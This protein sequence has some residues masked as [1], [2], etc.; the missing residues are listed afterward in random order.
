MSSAESSAAQQAENLDAWLSRYIKRLDLK[1]GASDFIKRC[2]E[3]E[4]STPRW[5]EEAQSQIESAI[6]AEL[7]N[8]RGTGLVNDR[9]VRTA[10]KEVWQTHE[11]SVT[12]GSKTHCTSFREVFAAS[13]WTHWIAEALFEAIFFDIGAEVLERL[14]G[15]P[16]PKE[17]L[18]LERRTALQGWRDFTTIPGYPYRPLNAEEE[19]IRL[20]V[21]LPSLDD[22]ATIQC[23]LISSKKEM[24]STYVALSY[25]W[26]Q[27]DSENSSRIELE[28]QTFEVTPNLY[29]A[30]RRLR[31]Q[32]T[33]IYLWVDALCINQANT[34]ERNDQVSRMN[35]IYQNATLVVCFLGEEEKESDIA[36]EFLLNLEEAEH[37]A[38][39]LRENWSENSKPQVY[40]LQA[41]LSRKYWKRVWIMQEI[42]LAQHVYICCGKYIISWESLAAFL[43]P[44]SKG[45]FSGTAAELYSVVKSTAKAWVI[46]LISLWYKKHNGIPI[47]R[48][49]VL[50]MSR[51]RKPTV[52]PDYVYGVTGLFDTWTLK[53]DYET[54]VPIFYLMVA[55]A[56]ITDE[57]NLDALSMCKGFDP[58]RQISDETVR[59]TI[60]TGAKGLV[61]NKIVSKFDARGAFFELAFLGYRCTEVDLSKDPQLKEAVQ[62]LWVRAG[63]E[64]LPSWVPRLDDN[65]I[66]P[67]QYILLN[68]KR[69]TN[70]QASGGIPSDSHLAASG[71]ELV[72]KGLILDQISCV[73]TSISKPKKFPTDF[74]DTMANR[75]RLSKAFFGPIRKDWEL[76]NAKVN[77]SHRWKVWDKRQRD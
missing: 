73:S 13:Q 36:M 7:Q 59:N 22:S 48:L 14:L 10:L 29:S 39:W 34:E 5:P 19:E 63:L 76:W 72:V 3:W 57:E 42:V 43:V 12:T 65:G 16:L 45:E 30:L 26:G 27:K 58:D 4:H 51:Q 28:G 11:E 70:D 62:S 67:F 2:H 69:N 6:L 74:E 35:T 37:K 18:E 68:R 9:S 56:A 31:S 77:K 15:R 64:T 53:I 20:L 25:C 61:K 71:K 33:K 52:L 41:L 23:K 32:T 49:D 21:V 1:D 75:K 47:S 44:P 17:G 50:V 55:T 54:P 46:P 66:R 8:P 38:S 40:A 60:N 24:H